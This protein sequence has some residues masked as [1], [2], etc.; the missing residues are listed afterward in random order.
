MSESVHGHEVLHFMVECGRGFSRESLIQAVTERFG[1]EARFH[2][3]SAEGM[4]AAQLVDFLA[5]RG[6]FVDTADGFSTR[7]DRICNH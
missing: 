5:A 1:P 3:C 6:K 7:P 4:T 2:T